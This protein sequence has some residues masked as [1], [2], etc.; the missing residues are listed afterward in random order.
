MTSNVNAR[1]NRQSP[2]RWRTPKLKGFLAGQGYV[3]IRVI[4]DTVCGLRRFNF[5]VGLVVGLSFEGYER[6]YCY[7]HARDALAALVAWDGREHPGGPWIKCKGAG[8]DLLNPAL[9]V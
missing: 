7:E 4:D 3:E 2:A 8:V 6:R 1:A 5:T 9:Q